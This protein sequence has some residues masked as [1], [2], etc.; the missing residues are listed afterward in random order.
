MI[1]RYKFETSNQ[2]LPGEMS[3]MTEHPH[4]DWIKFDDAYEVVKVLKQ[5]IAECEKKIN[6]V[7]WS[8]NKR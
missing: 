4:G 3:Q 6:A 1:K 7:K 5:Q 2:G 8:K